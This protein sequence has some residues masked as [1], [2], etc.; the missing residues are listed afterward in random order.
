MKLQNF[1]KKDLGIR[2]KFIEYRRKKDVRNL[3][4]LNLSW[5]IGVF[6]VEELEKSVARIAKNNI[7][8]VE[9][10]ADRYTRD[11]GKDSK[12]ILKVLEYYGVKASGVCGIETPESEFASNSPFV[13]Q[14]CIDYFRRSIDLCKGV[15]GTYMLFIPGAVG[16][17]IKYDN[18]EFLRAAEAVNTVGDYFLENGVRGAIEPVRPEEVSF[19]HTL[20]EAKEFID[21][22]DH[23]GIKNIGGDVFHMVTG[24]EHIS[25]SILKY[26]SMIIDLHIADTNRRALGSGFLDLDLILMALFMS[27]YNSENCYLTP[28]PLG[29]GGDP[30]SALYSTYDT[31]VLDELVK[32][33]AS[34]FY[35]RQEE[36]LN[37]S[38]SEI[39]DA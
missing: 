10:K 38:D 8:Y 39:I 13:R 28:E 1:Q 18:N 4:R 34:Y 27:G 2:K 37:A 17:P 14:R 5:Q 30:Y 21:A 15:G 16:R 3:R 32:D 29:T 24:E 20:A 22:V 9:L 25:S 33:S 6:G 31:R 23:P 35:E 19:C 11:I 7:S 12:E 26:G 36:I